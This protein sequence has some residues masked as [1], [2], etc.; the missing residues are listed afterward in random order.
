MQNGKSNLLRT[1]KLHY[2]K[3][4]EFEYNEDHL[5]VNEVLGEL[6]SELGG[7]LTA[8]MECSLKWTCKVKK[9]QHS[10]YREGVLLHG[11]ILVKYPASSSQTGDQLQ[12]ELNVPV[13][14]VFIDSSFEENEELAEEITLFIEDQ[15]WDLYFHNNGLVDLGPVL[16]EYIFLNRNP[17]PGSE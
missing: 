14:S 5:W 9:F 10:T 8:E 12:E 13:R 3:E 16:H 17:Y 4:S 6:V 11:E 7:E 2:G 1:T 15:E